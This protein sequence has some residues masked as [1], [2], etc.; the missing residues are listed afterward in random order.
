[1]TRLCAGPEC[2]RYAGHG[3]KYCRPHLAQR[4]AGLPLAPI[5][6][7]LGIC[8]GQICSVPGCTLRMYA[9]RTCR[10]HYSRRRNGSERADYPGKLWSR[11]T[12]ALRVWSSGRVR[13][14]PEVA[15]WLV[16]QSEARSM[17]LKMIVEEIIEAVWRDR[18]GQ[19][20]AARRSDIEI[21]ATRRVPLEL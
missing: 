9:L 10:I 12:T 3:H 4:R 15:R 21:E 5:P 7:K 6:R 13:L 19:P 18:R 20:A 2:D 17:P 8:K 1:M 11:S 14:R 16:A